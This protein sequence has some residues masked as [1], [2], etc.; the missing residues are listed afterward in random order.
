MATV[1]RSTHKPT[2]ARNRQSDGVQAAWH[3]VRWFHL[4][5]APRLSGRCYS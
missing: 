1:V 2:V 4:R 5:S 3:R